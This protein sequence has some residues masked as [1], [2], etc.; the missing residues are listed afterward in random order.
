[1]PTP[2]HTVGHVSFFRAADRVLISG[3]ALMTAKI[4]TVASLLLG[5]NGLSGPPWYMTWNSIAAH[6]S[7]QALAA[8]APQVLAGGHGI[9]LSGPGTADAIDDFA[10]SI[11]APIRR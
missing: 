9:P 4:D 8:L 5:R 7:I 6:E 1:V 10:E 11:A 2:G 3:D